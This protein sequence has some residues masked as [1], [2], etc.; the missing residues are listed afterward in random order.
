MGRVIFTNQPNPPEVNTGRADVACFI[1]LVR[2]LPGA[3]LPAASAAWLRSLGC[4]GVQ[5]ATIQDVP[6][7]LE[8]WAA[9]NS[10]FDSGGTSGSFGTDYLA[11]AVNSFFM[12]GGKRCYVVRVGD[13]VTPTDTEL[14]RGKKLVALLPNKAYSPADATSRTGVCCLAVLEEVSFVSTPDLPALCASAPVGIGGQVPFVPTGPEEFVECAQGDITPPQFRLYATAAPRLTTSDYANWANSVATILQYLV[15]GA[16][17]NELNLREMQYVAAFPLPQEMDAA[18]VNENP[19]SD[20]LAEDIHDALTALLPEFPEPENVV[21][22]A[23]IST[24]FLQLGYPWLKTNG[25]H[26]LLE[27]LEPPDGVLV[28][29]LARNALTR[30]SFT[31]ATKVTPSGVFDVWPTLPTN[32]TTSS[33]T[34][35]R[36]DNVTPKPLIERLSL[37]GFTP[38]GLRLLSD[39][40]AYPGET[41]RSAPVN[42]L[43]NVICRASRMTGEASTFE[44]NGPALWGRVQRGL[45]NLMTQLW[46]LNALDGAS[47]TDAFS[48]RCDQSTMTQNDLDNGRL[49]ANVTFTAASTIETI[50]VTLAMQ[51]G[52]TSV[53]QISSNLVGVS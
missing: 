38:S 42:R 27:G 43:V 16:T 15:S 3:A 1:G 9:F 17:R 29:L 48:V 25:S 39:V 11:A 35:L 34:A 6:V 53:Q 26:V 40:T 45:Q 21:T 28:G 32:D 10:V 19:S 46:S 23:N 36:W 18:A 31:S 7:L 30:G 50:N 4:T 44:Q 8:S 2:L 13:P 41:Y 12:Q 24:A 14:S 22:A 51:T 33:S 47:V 52:G 5:V 20:A 49:L 37:F